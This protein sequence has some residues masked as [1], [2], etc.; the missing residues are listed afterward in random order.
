MELQNTGK[1]TGDP[2]VFFLV[3]FLRLGSVISVI[4]RKAKDPL[5]KRVKLWY[6]TVESE[7]RS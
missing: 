1:N 4:R 5:Y 3:S 2:P 6:N 7:V